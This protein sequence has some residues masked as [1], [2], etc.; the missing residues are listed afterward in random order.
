MGILEGK[1]G[2]IT[3][4]GNGIG[5]AAAIEFAKQGANVIVND[6]AED[7]AQETAELIRANGGTAEVLIGDASNEEFAQELVAKTV[8]LWGSLDYAFNNAGI[9]LPNHPLTETK[10]EDWQRVFNVNVFGTMLLMKYEL[11]Q[12]YQQGHGA[13]LNTASLAGQS[14]NPGLACYNS[15]KWAVIGLTKT[16]AS[17]AAPHNLSLIHI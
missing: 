1:S 5:R 10:I 13:I 3:A 9:G 11:Q 4:G 7:P 17:E 8:E 16:A 14:G 15:S 2:L 6:I 12:M